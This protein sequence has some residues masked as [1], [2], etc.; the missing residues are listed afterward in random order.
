MNLP[1]S[2][3]LTTSRGYLDLKIQKTT[4]LLTIDFNA[5]FD[6]KNLLQEFDF[7]CDEMHKKALQ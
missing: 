4:Q 6:S 2:M 7:S 5:S 3:L 1:G